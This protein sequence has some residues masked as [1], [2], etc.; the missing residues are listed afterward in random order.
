GFKIDSAG[1]L[2]VDKSVKRLFDYF[3]GTVGE[4]SV[5]DIRHNLQALVDQT[6]AEPA[7]TQALSL[8]DN[9]LQ[10]K[11]AIH[12]YE[13]QVGETDL[14]SLQPHQ[15]AS[16]GDRLQYLEDLRR[17][18]LGD[19]AANAFY[20]DAEAVDRFTLT[21]L[22]VLNNPELSEAEKRAIV[23]QAEADLPVGVKAVRAKNHL[24]EKLAEAEAELHSS[25]A[26][27]HQIQS[28]RE[29]VLGVESAKAL[30]QVEHNQAAFR[31]KLAEYRRLKAQILNSPLGSI[32]QEQELH[33]VRESLFSG[34]DLSRVEAMER[35]SVANTRS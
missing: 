16:M 12:E 4:W 6:L 5:A 10:L 23:A 27:Q 19:S 33:R 18:Y 31:K 14:L 2:I 35:V 24:H 21:K 15:L 29:D 11:Q 30:A 13:Q 32:E 17:S 7:R 20:S 28:L 8:L 9:Y 3:L 22:N 26:D 1:N 34:K 25:G